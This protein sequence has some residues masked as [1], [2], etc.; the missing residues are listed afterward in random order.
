[1]KPFI[2]P[3]P[4]VTQLWRESLPRHESRGPYDYG[5]AAS[6]LVDIFNNNARKQP[7]ARQNSFG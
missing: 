3:V 2:G 4:R 1:L 7:R 6:W 5:A